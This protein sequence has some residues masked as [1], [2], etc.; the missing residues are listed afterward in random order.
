MS[1]RS[2]MPEKKNDHLAQAGAPVVD[3]YAVALHDSMSVIPSHPSRAEDRCQGA[4]QEQWAEEVRLDVERNF[5][6]GR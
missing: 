2:P 6:G 3:L 4:G 1:L 5:R